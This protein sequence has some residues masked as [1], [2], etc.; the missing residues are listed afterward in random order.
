MNPVNCPSIFSDSFNLRVHETITEI[1]PKEEG[2]SKRVIC[3]Y[4]PI[5]PGGSLVRNFYPQYERW[6]S[7]IP[8]DYLEDQFHVWISRPGYFPTPDTTA[9]NLTINAGLWAKEISAWRYHPNKQRGETIR[10][11]RSGPNNLWLKL[12]KADWERIVCPAD[13][14]LDSNGRICEPLPDPDCDPTIPECAPTQCP[15]GRIVPPGKPC[16][17]DAL[18]CD[19]PNA[20]E[21]CSVPTECPDGTITIAL[22]L[23]H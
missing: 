3:V 18:P 17:D 6:F 19:D 11:E 15:D 8:G 1:V 21:W 22:N 23:A 7:W 9:V 14:Q 12:R 10:I 5:Y 13:S 20:P 2:V 4:T 16:P